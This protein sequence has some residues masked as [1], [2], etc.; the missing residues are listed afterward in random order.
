MPSGKK[1]LSVVI[2]RGGSKGV[3]KKNLKL[4][5]VGEPYNSFIIAS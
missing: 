2:A 5:A 3:P 1:I 4:C